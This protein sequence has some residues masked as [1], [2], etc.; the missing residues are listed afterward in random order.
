MNEVTSVDDLW[1]ILSTHDQI[2][3]IIQAGT[4]GTNHFTEGIQG[5][6]NGHAYSVIGVKELSN[7]TKLVVM[8][9][10]WGSEGF[11]GD[12]SDGSALWTDELKEEA[13]WEQKNDGK[14]FMS[15][16]DYKEQAAYTLVA[17]DVT[18]WNTASFLKLNDTTG[19]NNSSPAWFC[20][21]E[22]TEHKFTLTSAVAQEVWLTAHTWDDRCMANKCKSDDWTKFHGVSAEGVGNVIFKY[23][24]LAF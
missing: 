4:G 19:S 20:G 24:D 10:P 12:W 5:L 22:C 7:G 14:F 17:K 9:N 2:D 16:A 1:N 15:V 13:G 8:R 3:D 23:G 6:A 18:D 21:E 11:T